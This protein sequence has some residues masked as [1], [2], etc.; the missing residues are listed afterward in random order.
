MPKR[1]LYDDAAELSRFLLCE[2]CLCQVGANQPK[3]LWWNG[4]VEGVVPT[5]APVLIEFLHRLPQLLI[6]L[7][8]VEGAPYEAD[9]LCQGLPRAFVEI[10]TGMFF[11]SLPNKILERLNIPVPTSKPGKSEGGVQHAPVSKVVDGGDELLSG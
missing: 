3:V 5:G 6:R 2:S 1:L 7:G 4:Q 11:D 8:V 10:G 9:A